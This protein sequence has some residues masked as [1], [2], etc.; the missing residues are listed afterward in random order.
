MKL[1]AEFSSQASNLDSGVRRVGRPAFAE[2][3]EGWDNWRSEETRG[4]K[5]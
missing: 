3:I 5:G 2:G 4:S 1:H